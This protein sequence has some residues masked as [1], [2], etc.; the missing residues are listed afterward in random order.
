MWVIMKHV[1]VNTETYRDNSAK[2]INLPTILI[3]YN[4]EIQ[5]IKQLHEYQIKY[6]T[7]SRSWHKKLIQAIGLLLD[8]LEANEDN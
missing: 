8:Y 5:I 6:H 1:K 2:S 4:G 3:E 7:K